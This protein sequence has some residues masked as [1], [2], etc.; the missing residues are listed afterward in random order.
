MMATQTLTQQ[1][2]YK[3]FL[4]ARGKFDPADFGVDL[5]PADFTDQAV[6]AFGTAYR[7]T[8][9]IDELLLHPREA[10]QFCDQF[11]RKHR[12]FDVPDDIILRV[13]LHRRKNP[14]G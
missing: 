3:E 6:E 9:T 14:E 12:Y 1:D 11:R 2:F 4:M 13:I 8:W 10:A 5:S 7:G